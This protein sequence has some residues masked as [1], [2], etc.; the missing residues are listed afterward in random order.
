MFVLY[1]NEPLSKQQPVIVHISNEQLVGPFPDR[2]AALAWMSKLAAAC[3]V[4]RDPKYG[5]FE[6][7]PDEG[8]MG[9]DGGEYYCEMAGKVWAE[10][11]TPTEPYEF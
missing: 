7:T 8:Y 3:N 5:L 1:H 2:A 9:I 11:V 4:G 10:L 6:V